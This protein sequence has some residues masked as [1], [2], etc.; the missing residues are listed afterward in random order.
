MKGNRTMNLRKTLMAASSLLFL[1]PAFAEDEGPV[2]LT[3][4]A[5]YK[6]GFG[7]ATAK[8]SKE[9][10]Y[11]STT[12]YLVTNG[13]TFSSAHK[14][15]S[16]PARTITFGEI[17]GGKGI[18]RAYYGVEYTGSGGLVFANGEC[19]THL[20]ETI[21]DIPNAGLTIKSPKEKPFL[22]YSDGY[23]G[24]VLKFN[25]FLKG[26]EG[27]GV[28]VHSGFYNESEGIKP[29]RLEFTGD[30]SGYLGSMIVTSRYDLAGS[31]IPMT[32][33]L[34]GSAT[35]FGGSLTFDHG[36]VFKP[37]VNTSVDSLLMKNGST[38]DLSNVSGFEVRGNLTIDE[39]VAINLKDG[40]NLKLGS[41]TLKD[42]VDF[43]FS[44]VSGLEVGDFTLEEGKEL[45]I[46]AGSTL[47]FGNAFNLSELPCRINLKG[48]PTSEVKEVTRYALIKLPA[49]STLTA[50]DFVIANK[51][52]E[53]AVQPFLSMVSDEDGKT[54]TLYVTYCPLINLTKDEESTI[55]Q[56]FSSVYDGGYWSDGNPVHGDAIYQILKVSGTT[57]F[58]LPYVEDVPYVFPAQAL[59]LGSYTVL[60]LRSNENIVSNVFLHAGSSG[61]EIRG[62]A[63]ECDLK[64]RS[65]FSISGELAFTLRNKITL[66]LDGPITGTEGS[67]I[68]I[69]SLSGSTDACRGW[70]EL[71]GEN[72]GYLGKIKVTSNVPQNVDYNDF[73]SLIVTDA[74]NLGGARSEFAY[75]ALTLE[76]YGQLDVRESMI[77]DEPTRGV[78]V[79][80]IGRMLVAEEKEL[81]IK[82]Q[83]T[84]NG[85]FYK[86]GAGT[87]ALGGDL[88]FLEF[89]TNFVESVDKDGLSKVVTNITSTVVETIP[90]DAANR[91][92][93]VMG[94]KV[95]PLT[96]YALDGL[97]V[98]FSNKTSKLDV[99]LALDI[100]ST[101]EELCAKGICNV[102]SPAPF[103]FLDDDAQK[104]APIYLE[105][106]DETPETEYSF[107]VMTVKA[108]CADALNLF[109]I[110]L[111]QSLTHLKLTT[112]KVADA[113]TVT[114]SAKLKKYGFA[115]SI[116]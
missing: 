26:A 31:V 93:Y 25:G 50:D 59:R 41:L 40:I 35:Y 75:D 16:I 22:I 21:I 60:Y 80:W 37:T 94:G 52:T 61:T 79:S 15:M 47:A 74:S 63:K 8:W 9:V 19:W 38:L 78:F 114:L 55:S 43:D 108:E 45:D 39:G 100:K 32:F 36:A 67:T 28:I 7:F 105:C 92:F 109:K 13:K 6:E 99:G 23:R 72:A 81:A 17:G 69:Q 27:C 101:D 42:G 3:E 54:K 71:N 2:V 24:G 106:N 10:E 96:A 77:L 103:A 112:T 1:L 107:N 66:R 95:K 58:S 91:T 48:A 98:V 20:A 46:R 89:E 82:Q 11:P 115:I 12:D 84:V 102:K 57:Y 29:Y 5:S 87:L 68:K 70:V 18:Y 56:G 4:S 62:P 53:V 86:E 88:R 113:G 65:R 14:E 73:A 116:R 51:G 30:V 33:T 85:K 97:D 34:S 90:N 44:L 64:L 111:P 49:E 110:V 76:R 104:K 83:L